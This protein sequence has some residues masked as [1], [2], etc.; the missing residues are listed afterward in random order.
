MVYNRICNLLNGFGASGDAP[1]LF[2][3]AIDN[4]IFQSIIPK[5]HD[6]TLK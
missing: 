1:N 6:E 3:V 4:V 2:S 5:Y